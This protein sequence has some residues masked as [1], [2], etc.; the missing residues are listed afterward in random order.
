MLDDCDIEDKLL[1]YGFIGILF[2]I[3]I[4]CLLYAN[5][6]GNDVVCIEEEKYICNNKL[7][8]KCQEYIKTIERVCKENK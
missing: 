1:F 3:F 2:L 4:V 7:N 8:N 5:K 6:N